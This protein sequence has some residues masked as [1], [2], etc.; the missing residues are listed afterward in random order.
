MA[1]REIGRVLGVD[2]GMKRTGLAVS[3]GLGISSRGL[4]NLTP[5]SRAEDVAVLVK[6]CTDEEVTDVAI[7]LPLMPRSGDVSPMSKRAAGFAQALQDALTTSGSSTKVHLVDERGSS[8]QAAERLVAS[9][10]KKGDRKALLDSEAARI[11]IELFLQAGPS[12]SMT[13]TTTTT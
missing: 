4:A 1:G 13:A 9:E 6:L 7:G 10:I 11:L 2:L 8:K 12:T 5:R 3:D